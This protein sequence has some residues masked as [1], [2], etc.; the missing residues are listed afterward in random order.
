[1]AM[2]DQR[3]ISCM[4]QAYGLLHG[5]MS[6]LMRLLPND[7]TDAAVSVMQRADN[8]WADGVKELDGLRIPY[9]SRAADQARDIPSE[10]TPFTADSVG[11]CECDDD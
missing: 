11:K 6:S 9:G 2:T 5:A 8:L 3:A 1:M 10:F 4:S 7:A